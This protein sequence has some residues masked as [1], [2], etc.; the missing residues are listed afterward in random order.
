MVLTGVKNFRADNA[1]WQPK[2]C[3]QSDDVLPA[4]GDQP[5]SSEVRGRSVQPGKVTL[6][7]FP[8]LS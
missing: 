5:S 4:S 6:S 3:G 7:L 2:R 8:Q 1:P